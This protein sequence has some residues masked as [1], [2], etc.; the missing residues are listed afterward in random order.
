MVQ[1]WG[2]SHATWTVAKGKLPQP[3][4]HRLL[5]GCRRQHRCA[6]QGRWPVRSA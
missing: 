2:C 5:L 6:H 1:V 4:W 3:L